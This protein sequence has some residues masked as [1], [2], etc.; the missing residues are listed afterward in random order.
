MPFW[1]WKWTWHLCHYYAQCHIEIWA[2][3]QHVPSLDLK[4]NLF[5]IENTFN[6]ASIHFWCLGNNYLKSVTMR[7]PSIRMRHCSKNWDTSQNLVSARVCSKGARVHATC[8]AITRELQER[9]PKFCTCRTYRPRQRRKQSWRHFGYRTSCSFSPMYVACLEIV[10]GSPYRVPFWIV[11]A[12][13]VS[14]IALKC[15]WSL[16][17]VN[18]II[19]LKK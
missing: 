11:P 13:L 12:D 15:T 10:Y 3:W 5:Q 2:E 16:C 18:C 9:P 4:L 8:R 6:M 1:P 17:T 19:F 7:L 14:T